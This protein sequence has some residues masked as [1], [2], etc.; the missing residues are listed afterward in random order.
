MK[1]LKFK[2]K[3][4]LKP[5]KATPSS[6]I[7]PIL[8][9]YGINLIDFCNKFNDLT[10]FI[11]LEKINVK[12]AIFNDNS[13]Q[14]L[15]NTMSLSD[16]IKE[17]KNILSFSKKPGYNQL[18]NINLND[19]VEISYFRNIYE[20]KKLNSLRKMMLGTLISMGYFNEK[21]YK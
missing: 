5:N 6:G 13:Y 10:K 4:I 16:Y 1:I 8:G 3:L 18:T 2:L 7:G 11:C 15:I 21:K 20:K 12:I 14:I 19:V 9:Q 17:K